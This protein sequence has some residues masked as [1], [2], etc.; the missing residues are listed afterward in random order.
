[1]TVIWVEFICSLLS[2]MIVT[3]VSITSLLFSTSIVRK[4]VLVAPE[5]NI[6]LITVGVKRVKLQVLLQAKLR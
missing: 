5:S 6:V 4:Y 1:M 2:C 3:Y